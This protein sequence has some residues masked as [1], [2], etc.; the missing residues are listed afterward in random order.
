M[1]SRTSQT[2]AVVK[3][4]HA[5]GKVIPGDTQIFIFSCIF[6]GLFFAVIFLFMLKQEAEEISISGNTLRIVWVK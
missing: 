5:S 4:A 1:R 2:Y 6:K 3:I